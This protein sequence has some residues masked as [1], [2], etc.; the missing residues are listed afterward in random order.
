M[1]RDMSD[2]RSVVED[3]VKHHTVRLDTMSQDTPSSYLCK[4]CTKGSG[5][6]ATPT[7]SNPYSHVASMVMDIVQEFL[8]DKDV[9]EYIRKVKEQHGA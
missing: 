5:A 9:E 6:Y 3:A 4:T 8:D 1:M 7:Y 2:L